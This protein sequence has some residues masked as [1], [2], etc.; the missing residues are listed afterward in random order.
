MSKENFMLKVEHENSFITSGPYQNLHL[1]AK[2]VQANL[3]LDWLHMPE[4]TFSHVSV[5][6]FSGKRMCTI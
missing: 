1:I 4:G 6:M 3:S 2:H 5:H